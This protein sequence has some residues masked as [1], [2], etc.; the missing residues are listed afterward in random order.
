MQIN[1]YLHERVAPSKLSGPSSTNAV[2]VASAAHC[3][4]RRRHPYASKALWLEVNDNVFVLEILSVSSLVS[5]R[6]AGA[7]GGGPS[8]SASPLH[9]HALACVCECLRSCWG[10]FHADII[11]RWCFFPADYSPAEV[12]AAVS[13]TLSYCQSISLLQVPAHVGVSPPPRGLGVVL[14]R[15]ARWL[16]ST[17]LPWGPSRK[18][19]TK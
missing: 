6:V 14:C 19:N 12:C 9:L 11:H 2:F 5:G 3:I 1:I 4:L 18:K 13:A 10:I 8:G 7:S 16:A 17:W 15:P